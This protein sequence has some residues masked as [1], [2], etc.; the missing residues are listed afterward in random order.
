MPSVTENVPPHDILLN[1]TAYTPVFVAPG[2]TLLPWLRVGALKT[3]DNNTLDT[4]F[5]YTITIPSSHNGTTSSECLFSINNDA[6]LLLVRQ[7][8]RQA[9]CHGAVV[10]VR[11]TD[12]QGLSVQKSFTLREGLS[13]LS[14]HCHSLTCVDSTH[15]S[16]CATIQLDSVCLDLRVTYARQQHDCWHTACA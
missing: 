1:S 3:L 15:C 8:S 5:N 12:T 2:D 6:N 4:V 13:V 9:T 14:L 16:R 7:V 10:T 11:S